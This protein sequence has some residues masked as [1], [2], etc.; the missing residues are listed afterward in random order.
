M[1]DPKN[2]LAGTSFLKRIALTLRFMPVFSLTAFFR[3]GAGVV[4]L[5]NYNNFM[6]FTPPFTILLLY[7]YIV[8]YYF[9][10][11]LLAYMLKLVMWDVKQLTAVE[12]SYSLVGECSTFTMW[13]NL[14]RRG[15]RRLQLAMNTYYFVSR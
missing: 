7:C 13:G 15:S 6:P 1:T 8:T 5:I 14:G 12:L 4:N 11:M 10:F 3:C 9:W 2:L